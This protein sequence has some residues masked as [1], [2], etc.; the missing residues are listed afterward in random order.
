MATRLFDLNGI[1]TLHIEY[2]HTPIQMRGTDIMLPAVRDDDVATARALFLKFAQDRTIETT[3]YGQV[4]ERAV[5][6]ACVYITGVYVADEPNVLFTS[7]SRAL[8][9]GCGRS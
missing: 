3:Q 6:S 1:Q 2:N 4:L 5:Q 8:R 9:R 7:T